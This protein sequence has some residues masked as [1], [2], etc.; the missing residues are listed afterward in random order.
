VHDVAGDEFRGGDDEEFTVA[1][2]LGLRH[3]E[4][5]EGVHAR[6]G[7]EF[8]PGAQDH[9]Q[10]DEQAHDEGGRDFADDDADRDDRH[11]HDVHRIAEL[12]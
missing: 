11:Q 8:L 1:N 9:V 2:H 10:R 3:L 4:L 12:L 6:P 5:R 7:L